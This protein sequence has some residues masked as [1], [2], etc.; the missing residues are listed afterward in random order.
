MS[1]GAEEGHEFREHRAKSAKDPVTTSAR[2][3]DATSTPQWRA[4]ARRRRGS[5]A[6]TTGSVEPTF[7]TVVEVCGLTVT[8]VLT[9]TAQPP[10]DSLAVSGNVQQLSCNQAL[11]LV[12]ALL[13]VVTRMDDFVEEL[14]DAARDR[15]S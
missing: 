2:P 11:E 5:R 3:A 7:Q 12:D 15:E 6:T 8:G 9:G 4:R 10:V 13:L 1:A 14:Y